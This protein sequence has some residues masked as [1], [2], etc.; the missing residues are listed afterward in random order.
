M[1][2]WLRASSLAE[3]LEEPV[4]GFNIWIQS[5]T[6]TKLLF[7]V[8]TVSMSPTTKHAPSLRQDKAAAPEQ[9]CARPAASRPDFHLH[10]PFL[11][12]TT[13]ASLEQLRAW[14]GR[15]AEELGHL[16]RQGCC[17]SL[18]APAV[19]AFRC[20]AGVVRAA[21][22]G[23]TSALAPWT[24]WLPK[25]ACMASPQGF[26]GQKNTPVLPPPY[27]LPFTCSSRKEFHQIDELERDLAGQSAG[28]LAAQ[29]EQTPTDWQQ[30]Q[31]QLG[32][33][34]QPGQ[35]QKRQRQA[36]E[37]AADEE[38]EVGVSRQYSL[39]MATGL[40]LSEHPAPRSDCAALA[41]AEEMGSLHLEQQHLEQQQ[42]LG[43]PWTV[44]ETAAAATGSAMI[45]DWQGH[46]QHD[47]VV[48]VTGEE[49]EQL[50]AAQPASLPGKHPHLQDAGRLAGYKQQEQQT[51]QQLRQPSNKLPR[52]P[53]QPKQHAP[54]ETGAI[55]T[56]QQQQ[57]RQQQPAGVAT[58]HFHPALYASAAA[59]AEPAVRGQP[60]PPFGGLPL[61]SPQPPAALKL[62]HSAGS[63]VLDHAE[64]FAV[65]RP[66]SAGGGT[67]VPA[68]SD[69]RRKS[70]PSPPASGWQQQQQQQPVQQAPSTRW[71]LGR[72]AAVD[73]RMAQPWSTP[74]ARQ[75]SSVR[76][77]AADLAADAEEQ[78]SL[79]V[80]QLAGWQQ[81][82]A[83]RQ[84]APATL[85]G[86]AVRGASAGLKAGADHLRMQR[87]QAQ[88]N[89]L[90]SR[91]QR[92]Q[93]Q[94]E[95]DVITVD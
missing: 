27:N 22:C 52:K 81:Q 41:A 75:Q 94:A 65:C 15:H 51:G 56:Q 5:Q 72:P 88:Q 90:L 67:S 73:P 2:P 23:P 58:S 35:R 31:Q 39:D 20:A 57:R 29:R 3:Q 83:H 43:R 48:D 95:P 59:P 69:W 34:M 79:R 40:P 82:Q 37:R 9:H 30:Q 62:M 36:A 18:Q 86:A 12:S 77:A 17:P 24:G 93:Q 11:A 32:S 4:T 87:E 50:A 85:S 28:E 70:N 45:A 47:D 6:R 91:R 54:T 68:K 7:L 74:S 10:I 19:R 25:F 44:A 71:E 38:G 92:K 60:P 80:Q 63:D 26:A 66:G 16:D 64:P 76:Q 13:A 89:T 1:T 21:S 8:P 78:A 55:L 33:S 42:Q 61:A 53:S 49:D 46:R 14:Q 84:L